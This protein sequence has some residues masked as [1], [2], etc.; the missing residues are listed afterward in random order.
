MTIDEI[1]K[2]ID[3]AKSILIL[4][5]K[6]PDGDAIGSSLAM[7]I[8]LKNFKKNVEIVIPDAPLTY[9]FLPCYDEIKKETSRDDFDLIIT[10]DLGQVGGELLK[11]LLK[12]Q[13]INLSKNY[14]DCG[15]MIFDLSDTD[16]AAGGSGCGCSASVLCSYIMKQFEAKELSRVLKKLLYVIPLLL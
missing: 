10:G 12:K 4:T 14:R 11:Q 7:Y 9:S 3:K 2:K 8:T 15:I 6:N 1:K 13:G 16:V 5:H